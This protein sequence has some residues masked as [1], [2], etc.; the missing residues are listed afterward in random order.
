MPAPASDAHAALLR[1]APLPLAE[2]STRL[3]ALGVPRHAGQQALNT[4]LR[5]GEVR[6]A[7]S[8]NGVLV[9][10]GTAP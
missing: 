4:A 8:G 10:A 5:A 1:L 9:V 2:I 7:H 3:A 6:L